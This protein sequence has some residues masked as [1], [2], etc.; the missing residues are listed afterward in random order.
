VVVKRLNDIG[1]LDIRG[2]HTH[3][4]VEVPLIRFRPESSTIPFSVQG[5]NIHLDMSLPIWHSQNAFGTPNTSRFGKV[6]DL[7]LRGSYLYYANPSPDHVES[8][9]LFILVSRYLSF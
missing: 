3:A 6:D 5:T 4:E 1:F 9:T 7:R 8:L 2:A